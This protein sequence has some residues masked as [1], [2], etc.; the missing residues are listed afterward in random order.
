MEV[1]QLCS[2]FGT[3]ILQSGNDGNYLLKLG[4]NFACEVYANQ[5]D[6]LNPPGESQASTNNDLIA[7]RN[8]HQ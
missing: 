7:E 5:E 6:I 8:K 2:V 1:S 4:Q 3:S